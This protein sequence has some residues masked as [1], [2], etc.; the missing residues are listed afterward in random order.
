[1]SQQE[2][3]TPWGGNFLVSHSSASSER[4]F[5]VLNKSATEFRSA[6]GEDTLCAIM[7]LKYNVDDCCH[8][9]VVMD[10]DIELLKRAKGA[11]SSYNKAHKSSTKDK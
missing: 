8:P 7:A 9:D 5:S 3:S 2:L 4:A 1:M 11:T 10:K 6:L